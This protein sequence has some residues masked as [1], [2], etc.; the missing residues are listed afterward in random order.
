MKVPFE[1]YDRQNNGGQRSA[2]DPRPRSNH[3]SLAA[4]WTCLNRPL[5]VRDNRAR[6]LIPYPQLKGLAP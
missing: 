6:E 2:L 3:A 4:T 1:H 5:P